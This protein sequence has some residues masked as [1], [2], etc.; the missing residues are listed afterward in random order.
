MMGNFWMKSN[1]G[2]NANGGLQ[3]EIF[4]P[5]PCALLLT[6]NVTEKMQNW[7]DVLWMGEVDGPLTHKKKQTQPTEKS[8]RGSLN[9]L[10]YE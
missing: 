2:P 3:A 4:G 5:S 6:I 7:G 1:I 8:S 9:G 10:E